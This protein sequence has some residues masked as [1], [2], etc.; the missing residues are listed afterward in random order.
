MT[1]TYDIEE[2][3]FDAVIRWIAQA[4]SPELDKVQEMLTA[5]RKAARAMT[6]SLALSVMGE[7]DK[8]RIGTV[9]PK[10]MIGLTGT[11]VGRSDKGFKV[12]LDEQSML[13]ARVKGRGRFGYG[14]PIGIVAECL[15]KVED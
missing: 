5:R 6:R 13:T 11:I 14:G 15:T 8:V 4:P 10:Y 2:T 12:K 7:G 1:K 3:T 9:S